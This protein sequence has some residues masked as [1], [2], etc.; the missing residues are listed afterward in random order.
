MPKQ[1][2]HILLRIGAALALYALATSAIA[3]P[4]GLWKIN[5]DGT[6]LARFAG[7]PDHRCGS[8]QW[9]PDGKFVAFDTWPAG[10]SNLTTIVQIAVVRADGSGLRLIGHGAM[11][12]WSPDCTQIVCHT[13][14]S[15]Q[16]MVVMN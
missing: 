7:E 6:G 11:P 13:N 2:N 15:P 4:R 9:S 5:V 14:D 16:T 10:K 8:P 1:F 3:A 12:S